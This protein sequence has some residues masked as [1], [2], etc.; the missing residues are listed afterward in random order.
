MRLFE[1]ESKPLLAKHGI[2]IPKGEPASSPEEVEAALRSIPPPVVL[3]AQVTVGRRGKAGGVKVARSLEEAMELSRELLGMEVHGQRVERILV[4][5]FVDAAKELFLSITI[6]DSAGRPI[7]LASSEGGVEIEELAMEHPEKIVRETI[8]PLRGLRGYEARR[9]AKAM[10]LSGQTMVEV[11][12][13]LCALYQAF[14]DYDATIVEVNP[15]ALTKTGNL[16]AIGSVMIIDDDAL[17]RH[18]ELKE[19]AEGRIEDEIE[20]LA[21]R[22]GIPYVRLDGDIGVIG[23]GAGLATATVD[24]LRSYGGR[25]A[26]FL[27]TGGRITYEHMKNCLD[28]V[29]RNPRVRALLVNLYGGINPIVEGAK[30]IVDFVK[31]RGINVPMVVK[32]RGNFEEEAWRILE[33]AGIEVVKSSRTEEAAQRIVE[34]LKGVV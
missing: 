26:N 27:D 30:G 12:R 6:D 16:C 25:P 20:R 1:F 7:I 18:P 15:L 19:R 9:I 28:L 32:V 23:S 4:E 24:V 29:F 31:E 17:D 14:V 22:L 8:D 21:F 33:G 3:K 13:I 11:G 2:P 10:G 34:K 5:E